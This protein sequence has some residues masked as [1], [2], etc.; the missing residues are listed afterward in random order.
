MRLG[1]VNI[2]LERLLFR[3]E[4]KILSAES[5]AHCQ[6]FGTFQY[7]F[8][9]QSAKNLGPR[10][11][12]QLI[13]TIHTCVHVADVCDCFNAYLRILVNTYILI[14]MDISSCLPLD[15]FFLGEYKIH[16]EIMEHIVRSTVVM[17]KLNFIS[18]PHSFWNKFGRKIRL[19]EST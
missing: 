19:N 17:T 13:W 9:I 4:F 2:P 10:K 12:Y 18:I 1:S 8:L 7:T 14:A 16:M 6:V 15:Q 5:Q 11:M 3:C